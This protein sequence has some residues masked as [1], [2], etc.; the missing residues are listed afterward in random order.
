M[1]CIIIGAGY[2]DGIY[3]KATHAYAEIPRK[4][5]VLCLGCR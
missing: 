5:Q 1:S 3:T 2:F 4:G